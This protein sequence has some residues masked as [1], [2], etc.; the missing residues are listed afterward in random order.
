V[1]VTTTSATTGYLTIAAQ[2]VVLGTGMGLTTAPAT[3]AIMSVVPRARAGV[4]SAVNDATRLF[5]GTLG[6]AVIGS[7]Y[8]SLYTRHLSGELPAALP[9]ALARTAHSSI[10]AAL[11]VAGRLDRT[12]HP[13]LALRVHH[14]AGS[15]FF[16]GFH[17]A[18]LL[19]AGVAAAGAVMAL[20][21]LPGR[22]RSIGAQ[23]VVEGPPATVAPIATDH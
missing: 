7:V 11:A 4:G 5:G 1:W 13:G 2:M 6:V 10:G 3:E 16:A 23:P 21:L 9:S 14:Q 22:G 15:A 19:A 17:A 20:A 18:N 12:G 8:S